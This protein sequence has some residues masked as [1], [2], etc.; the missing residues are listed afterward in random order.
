MKVLRNTL[1]FF[2][3]SPLWVTCAVVDGDV[4]MGRLNKDFEKHQ[5]I[6][7]TGFKSFN[8]V[9]GICL[10][11]YDNSGVYSTKGACEASCGG[12]TGSG[13]GNYN[14]P[15]NDPQS[16][17]LC[18]AAYAYKCS[19]NQANL[20]ASCETYQWYQSNFGLPSCPYCN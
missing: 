12:S 10:G 11:E 8:C 1:L 14:G 2:I 20:K 19:N 13:C 5:H 17:T 6:N 9:Q 7:Y 15:T 18:Q 4:I 16:A 3:I